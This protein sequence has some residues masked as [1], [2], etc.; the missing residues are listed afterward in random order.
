MKSILKLGTVLS[1]LSVFALAGCNNDSSTTAPKPN[2]GTTDTTKPVVD[3]SDTEEEKPS[4]PAD[5]DDDTFIIEA[6]YTDLG[7]KEG[8]GYSGGAVGREM[9]VQDI[10]GKAGASNGFYVSYL[11]GNG[12]D[13]NFVFES[14]KAVEDAHL[15]L[16]LSAELKD[17]IV[18]PDTWAIRVNGE[19]QSYSEIAFRGVPDMLSGDVLPFRD[20][21]DLV[22]DLKE[23]QNEI[24]LVTTNSDAM[25]GTMYA[26]APMVDC[27]K[28]KDLSG[29]TLSYDKVESNLD[30][31]E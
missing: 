12:L 19:D 10:D 20:C 31:F 4:S 9:I 26:T 23:G 22:I 11:Y 18:Y 17:I 28:I 5:P 16:R 7:R 14:D 8:H 25:G 24:D 21:L 13:L 15:S 2:P 3:S 27:I 1:L 30:I 29:A 6:E